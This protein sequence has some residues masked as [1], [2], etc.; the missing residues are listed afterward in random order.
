MAHGHP[1]RYWFICTV[2]FP[3]PACKAA[4]AETIITSGTGPDP[5]PVHNALYRQSYKCQKCLRPLF[6]G[7]HIT[8]SVEPSTLD[9]IRR[10]GLSVTPRNAD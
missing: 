2:K 5:Q 1:T 8:V 7:S 9:E 10:R 3:C 4:S 6:A